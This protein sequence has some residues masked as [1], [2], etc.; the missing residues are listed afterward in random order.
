MAD[1]RCVMARC[2][3]YAIGGKTSSFV[4]V[5]ISVLYSMVSLESLGRRVNRKTSPTMLPPW[6]DARRRA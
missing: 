4:I 1:P 6:V 5:G 3:A 2:R